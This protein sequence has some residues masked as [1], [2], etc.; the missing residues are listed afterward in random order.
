MWVKTRLGGLVITH[1]FVLADSRVL[2]W[3]MGFLEPWLIVTKEG[4]GRFVEPGLKNDRRTRCFRTM[5]RENVGNDKPR[6]AIVRTDS[7]SLQREGYLLLGYTRSNSG[8][9][10]TGHSIRK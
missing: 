1:K 5:D 8:D 7:P 9:P 6:R 10:V 4:P 2:P 3:N